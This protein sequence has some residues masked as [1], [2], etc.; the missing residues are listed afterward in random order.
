MNT[1][2]LLGFLGGLLAARQL[3]E[4]VVEGS[5]ARA[6]RMKQISLGPPDAFPAMHER[7]RTQ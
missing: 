4:H 2:V 7:Q 5:F 3:A 6:Q 1:K